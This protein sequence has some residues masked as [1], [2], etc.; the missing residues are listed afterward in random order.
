MSADVLLVSSALFLVLLV[1][2]VDRGRVPTGKLIDAHSI[3]EQKLWLEVT[4]G[5]GGG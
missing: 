3:V 1:E 4:K 5:R 2:V